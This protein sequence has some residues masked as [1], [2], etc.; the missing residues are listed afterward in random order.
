MHLARQTSL[1]PTPILTVPLSF[2]STIE[3]S[4]GYEAVCFLCRVIKPP[5]AGEEPDH[6]LVTKASAELGRS[7]LLPEFSF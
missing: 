3:P 4:A 1:Q 7:E 5:R 2:R 6:C